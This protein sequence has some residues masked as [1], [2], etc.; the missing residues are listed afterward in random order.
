MTDF[1]YH[2]PLLYFVPTKYLWFFF[3][4]DF[5]PLHR[6]QMELTLYLKFTQHDELI[7]ELVSTGDAELIEVCWNSF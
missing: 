5:L 6:P 3:P 4:L 7:E 1:I 2:C